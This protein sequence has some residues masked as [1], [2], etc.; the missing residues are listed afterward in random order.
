MFLPVNANLM[1]QFCF[2]PFN[3]WS[4]SWYNAIWLFWWGWTGRPKMWSALISWSTVRMHWYILW[5]RRCKCWQDYLVLTLHI[6]RSKW[7]D[8]NIYEDSSAEHGEL[9][10]LTNLTHITDTWCANIIWHYRIHSGLV[11]GFNNI[12]EY[13][14]YSVSLLLL[15]Q[16]DKV[17]F[18]NT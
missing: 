3:C 9:N 7:R 1:C 5:R 11:S 15:V 6:T 16:N 10:I 12:K 17:R 18:C 8:I 14:F 13:E 4:L 2:F